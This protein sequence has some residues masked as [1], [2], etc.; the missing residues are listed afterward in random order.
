MCLILY[1]KTVNS[2]I[3][4]KPVQWKLDHLIRLNLS[5]GFYNILNMLLK[6]GTI[7]VNIKYANTPS[8]KNVFKIYIYCYCYE[9]RYS[10][11]YICL[12]FN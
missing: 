2:K 12:I 3:R 1:V 5:L 7:R 4:V 11:D 6:F 9:I 10:I 8:I